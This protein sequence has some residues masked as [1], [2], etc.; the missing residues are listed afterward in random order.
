MADEVLKFVST[1]HMDKASTEVRQLLSRLK[2]VCEPFSGI[3]S[4]HKLLKSLC[5][6]SNVMSVFASSITDTSVS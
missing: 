6:T 1:M 2:E 5:T 3:E 4:K